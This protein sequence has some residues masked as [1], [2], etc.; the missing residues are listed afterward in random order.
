MSG[1]IVSLST[2]LSYIIIFNQHW[3]NLSKMFAIF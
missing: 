2:L 3:G 1:F